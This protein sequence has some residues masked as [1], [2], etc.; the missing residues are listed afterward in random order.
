MSLAH[1]YFL[2][3]AIAVLVRLQEKGL[4]P[5]GGLLATLAKTSHSIGIKLPKIRVYAGAVLR[6]VARRQLFWAICC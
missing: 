3:G 5:L 6:S 4:T 1:G 2:V